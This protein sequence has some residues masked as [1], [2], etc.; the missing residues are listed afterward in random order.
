L[1]RPLKYR[2]STPNPKPNSI[3]NCGSGLAR[4]AVGQSTMI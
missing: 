2:C 3:Q 1:Y 4:E